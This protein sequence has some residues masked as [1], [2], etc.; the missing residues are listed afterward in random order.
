MSRIGKK[1]I[2]LPSGVNVEI[3]KG[4]ISVKGP[5]GEL[6]EKLHPRVAVAQSPEGLM[7]S[8]PT[9]SDKLDRALWGTWGSIIKNMIKGVTEGYKKQLEING[10]GYKAAMKGA[11]ALVVEAGY[12]HPVEIETLP[13][14]KLS[15]EKNII[16]VEG[17]SK[18]QVGEMAARIRSIKKPEPYKGKG[19]R[20]TDEVVRRKA[21]KAASKAA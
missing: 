14:V 10:V 17:I 13:G 4:T 16:T 8:V 6:K 3:G 18:Q 15:V 11:N 5:K 1:P 21:G 7:V 20:Y 2:T 9:T 19:I 12:S